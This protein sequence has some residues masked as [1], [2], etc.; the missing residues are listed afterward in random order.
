MSNQNFE[1]TELFEKQGF[2]AEIGFGRKIAI[3]LVDFQHA[4][5]RGELGG[6]P[7]GIRAVESTKPLLDAARS[8]NIPLFYTLV[9]YEK[10][11]SDAGIFGKK[12]PGLAVCSEGSKNCTIDPLI[13]PQENDRVIVKKM[14]SAFI[15]TG[16]LMH[17]NSRD[18]DTLVITGMTTS[19]CVR[20][21]VVDGISYG[22]RTIVP[23]ECVADRDENAHNQSLFDM[24]NKYADVMETERVIK[25]IQSL[26]PQ[27]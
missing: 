21:T 23:R 7:E 20:A 12:I 15:G 24:G 18:V 27:Q 3:I 19:G 14:A 26:A 5:T 13:P 25:H 1:T 11:L 8:K 9:Q 22:F 17:L 2:A 10:D 6:G 4:F 16:L